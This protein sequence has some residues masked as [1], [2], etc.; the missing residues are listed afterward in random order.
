MGGQIP[1]CRQT[2]NP[3][4]SIAQARSQQLPQKEMVHPKMNPFL[5]FAGVSLCLCSV[6]IL[7]NGFSTFLPLTCKDL[8]YE[9]NSILSKSVY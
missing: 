4:I 9:L 2:S 5:L 7:T 6:P 1:S 3:S 8:C